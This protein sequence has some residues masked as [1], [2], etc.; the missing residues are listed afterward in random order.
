MNGIVNLQRRDFLKTGAL[1]GGGLVLG[2][3]LPLQESQGQA[4]A[5]SKGPIALNAFI[6]IG[7]DNGVTILVNKSE[8]GQGVYT[9]LPM[10]V[11]EELECDWA[12]VRVESAP[13][14]PVY[15]H[16]GFGIQMTGGSTSVLSE[17]ERMRKVGA[18]AR[19]MLIAAAAD[20]WKV[21]RTSCRAEKGMVIHPGAKNSL[22]DNWPRRPRPCRCRK[23]SGSRTRRTSKSSASLPGVWTPRKRQTGRRFSASMLRSRAC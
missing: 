11:A 4:R 12:K 16:T 23:K 22:T 8:M 6:R 9:S 15:N 2:F 19:E 21:E 13:V 17:W 18:A 14:D 5:E 10:L 20:L 7:R 1:L 3:H